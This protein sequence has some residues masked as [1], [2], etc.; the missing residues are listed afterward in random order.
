MQWELEWISTHLHL[1]TSPEHAEAVK[2]N[3][4]KRYLILCLQAR[5]KELDNAEKE[6][7]QE[8]EVPAP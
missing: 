1:Y 3:I 7:G 6:K 4:E 2:R 5:I 8:K